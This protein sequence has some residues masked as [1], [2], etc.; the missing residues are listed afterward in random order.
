MVFS[1]GENKESNLKSHH[2]CILSQS[3]DTEPCNALFHSVMNFPLGLSLYQY[4]PLSCVYFYVSFDLEKEVR[5]TKI[6]RL[7][8]TRGSLKEGKENFAGHLGN[9][10]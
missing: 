1:N 7:R 4:F 10:P 8:E 5:E 3:F 9:L 2:Y 6:L